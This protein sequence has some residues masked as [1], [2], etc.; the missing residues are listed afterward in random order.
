MR[1]VYF[2]ADHIITSLGFTTEEN[3]RQIQ[4]G[5]SGIKVLE[6]KSL[7][8]GPVTFSA[9][10]TK[11]LDRRFDETRNKINI[12]S[13]SLNYTRLEK[14][15]LTSIA[16]ALENSHVDPRNPRTIMIFSTTKGNID[17]LDLTIAKAVGCSRIYLWQ[18]A[19]FIAGHFN[20]PNRPLVISNACTSGSVA[21]MAAARLIASGQY[22]HAIV[23]GGDIVSEFVISGFQ[24]FQALS[25]E[26][27]KP[28]DI[29]RTG[30]SLGEGCGT[31]V[32]TSDQ[33]LGG[34]GKPIVYLGGATSNDANHISG[35]SRDGEG[36]YLS[37][38]AAMKEAGVTADDLDFISAH[39]TATPYNDEMESLAL[40]WAG[41]DQ[42]PV[43]SFK[44]Y[45]GHTLG[46][47]GV[48][49]TILSV[50][51]IRKGILFKSA[52]YQKNGVS[53]PLNVITGN[54]HKPVR[55]ILKTASG[56]GGCNAGLVIGY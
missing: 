49:E 32:L 4:A 21:I 20:H 35:P 36:L 19:D 48:I 51:S 12:P 1:R 22:D 8:P 39:G 29:D 30:L 6:D 24:S 18:L 50:Y 53:K 14:M 38:A 5:I 43:N 41:L 28:F 56:F 13:S 16:G 44:G 17:L 45:I 10:N 34:E 52:G 37:I 23:S 7:F 27:C 33:A 54:I 26:A 47:A 3:A 11:E 2:G 40:A 42:V 31:V 9:I 15:F 46:A 25:P 55:R